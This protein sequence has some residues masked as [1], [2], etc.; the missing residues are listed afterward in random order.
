LNTQTA[1]AAA[2]DS[3]NTKG[4]GKQSPRIPMPP[5]WGM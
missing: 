4:G 5:S 3:I 1:A 2:R